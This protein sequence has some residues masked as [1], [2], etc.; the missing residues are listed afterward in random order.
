MLKCSRLH[1][2]K[3]QH[4]DFIVCLTGVTAPTCRWSEFRACLP[5]FGHC[6]SDC[7]PEP[8]DT[9]RI[10][11]R[12]SDTFWLKQQQDMGSALQNTHNTGT[13]LTI[14]CCVWNRKSIESKP[15]NIYF[16]LALLLTTAYGWTRAT[17]LSLQ[18]LVWVR[19]KGCVW[20]I[21][22]TQLK[23]AVHPSIFKTL[24]LSG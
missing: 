18:L 15:S 3:T 23:A 21:K 22:H 12:W 19:Q 16:S 9:E 2:S 24:S 14:C 5:P 4:F 10:P 20:S 1:I 17:L 11:Y 7:H 6:P 8:S 13:R